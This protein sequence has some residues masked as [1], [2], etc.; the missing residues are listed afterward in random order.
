MSNQW[1]PKINTIIEDSVVVFD[2]CA[3]LNV[4]R[5]SVVSSKRILN[6][7]KQHE[8][9]IWIP[10]QVKKEFNKN[11]DTVR[12][13]NL[14][15][16]LDKKLSKLIEGKKNELLAQLSEYEK[17]RFSNLQKKKNQFEVKFIELDDIVKE[18]KKTVSEES[19]VYKEFIGEVDAFFNDLLNSDKV[20]T[21]MNPVHL[22]EV[23]KEGELRYKY[24]LPPGYEDAKTKEGIDRFGDLIMWK[25]IIKKAGEIAE[26]NIIF[27]T[28]DTKPDWFLKNEKDEV[29]NP[30][31]ELISEFKH[32]YSDKE[33]IIIPFE[34]YIE[35]LS[36]PFDVSDKDLLFELRMNNLVKRLSQE[37]FRGIVEEKIESLNIEDLRKEM[38][39][40]MGLVQ[41]AFVENIS[42]VDEAFVEN[43]SIKTNGIEVRADEV[44]YSVSAIADCKFA[45][46]SYFSNLTSYG[47]LYANLTLGIELKRKLEENELS[48]IKRFEEKTDSMVKI[49]HFITND[50]KYIWEND[51]DIFENDDIDYDD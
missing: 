24:E 40:N 22:I 31:K 35:E 18:Y 34:D 5:Y 42:E 44:V 11:R 9:K 8:N 26:K 47:S 48:F 14:Y 50:E 25:E 16:S 21:E 7:I 12:S 20:G 10:S 13:V 46:I 38:N 32:Y 19:G 30:R 27:V 28:S 4:Y 29:V 51:F 33:V 41:S 45:T 2:T 39:G 23:L 15:K 37:S 49:T 17:K 1:Y 43:I 3:L 36:N 6:Y